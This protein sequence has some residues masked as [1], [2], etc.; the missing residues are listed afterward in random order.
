[1]PSFHKANKILIAMA[2]VVCMSSAANASVIASSDMGL[3]NLRF[4]STSTNAQLAWTDVWYGTVQAQAQ[5][6]T[7]GSFGNSDS[8]LG[9]D[10]SI[11]VTVN[12]T[13]VNSSASYAVTNGGQP[14]LTIGANTKSSLSL[15]AA[16]Q[17]GDGSATA[18]FDNYFVIT[19]GN[20]GDAVDV[21]FQ[22]DYLGHLFATS[23]DPSDFFSVALAAFL[24]LQDLNGNSLDSASV[25]DLH[26]GT[27]T[28]FN[29]P[30]YAGTLTVSTTLSYGVG[31]WLYSQADSEVYGAVPEPGTVPLM[32]LGSVLLPLALKRKHTPRKHA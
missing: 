9:N 10:G 23:S 5:D 28:T 32:L 29:P 24:D 1:M 13:H 21:T 30:P 27:N 12:S 19:G 2:A 25:S 7:S 22:L 8:L 31:Y 3:S 20:F 15:F 11:G 18:T 6:T 26:S 16:G 4:S 17:Q 14:D